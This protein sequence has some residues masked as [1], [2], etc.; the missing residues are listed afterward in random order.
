MQCEQAQNMFSQFVDDELTADDRLRVEEH[1]R[2]CDKCRAEVDA[3]RRISL[4]TQEFGL[5]PP[6]PGIWPAIEKELQQTTSAP[7]P[8]RPRTK[9]SGLRIL[10][11]AAIIVIFAGVGWMFLPSGHDHLAVDFDGYLERFSQ[12][13]QAAQ[14]VLLDNYAYQEVDLDQAAG[15]LNYRPAATTTL[16][17]DY[18]L[19][20]VY[21]FEMPC[22]RCVQTIYSRQGQEML[23]LFEHDMEQP[24]WFGDRPSIRAQCHGKTTRIVEFDRKLVASWPHGKRHITLVGA[25]D[26]KE[27]LHVVEALNSG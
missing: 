27:V 23:V 12:N 4:M 5:Q 9:V 11:T 6:P 15:L 26:M 25:Q 16:P 14:Q 1:L 10:T 2:G 3:I 17:N 19:E 22:C 24:V 20:R 21:V 8:L 7:R 13:P 18:T